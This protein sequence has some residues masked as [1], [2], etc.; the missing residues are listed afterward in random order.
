[1]ESTWNIQGAQVDSTRTP[2]GVHLRSIWNIWNIQGVHK[3][4]RWSPGG[5]YGIYKEFR[6]SPQGVHKDFVES[7]WSPRLPV[8]E[9]N[10]QP[11]CQ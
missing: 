3:E 6:R 5:I 2:C 11:D 8:G 1:V 10:L 9:C 7:T 4:S